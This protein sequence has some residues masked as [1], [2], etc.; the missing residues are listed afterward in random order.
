MQDDLLR[1][2][3]DVATYRALLVKKQ[4]QLLQMKRELDAAGN[5]VQETTHKLKTAKREVRKRGQG[6]AAPTLC[7]D[8]LWVS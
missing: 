3:G 7:A 6:V 2:E 8:E 4:R 5:L 1:A